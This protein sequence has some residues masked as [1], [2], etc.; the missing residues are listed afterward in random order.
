MISRILSVLAAL[1]LVA[2]GT[3]KVKPVGN[4]KR[5]SPAEM[6]TAL[7]PTLLLPPPCTDGKPMPPIC[8]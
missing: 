2:S 7:L 3:A 5:I 1:G 4:I 8:L 6:N